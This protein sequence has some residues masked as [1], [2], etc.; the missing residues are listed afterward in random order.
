[1]IRQYEFYLSNIDACLLLYPQNTFRALYRTFTQCIFIEDDGDIIFYKNKDGKA[2][3]VL[4]E[5]AL[6]NEI[7]KSAQKMDL[8]T[9]MKMR[10]FVI[11]NRREAVYITRF[12][13]FVYCF[14]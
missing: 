2:L 11:R 5:G 7:K 10:A 12:P 6:D 13:I 4:A 14:E 3:R 9:R 1:M 8:D